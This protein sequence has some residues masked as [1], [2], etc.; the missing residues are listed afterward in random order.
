MSIV[1]CPDANQ[2]IFP[3]KLFFKGFWMNRN[4]VFLKDKIFMEGRSVVSWTQNSE[5][6][7]ILG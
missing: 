5:E 1:K 3:L 4:F 6:N 2:F 7:V